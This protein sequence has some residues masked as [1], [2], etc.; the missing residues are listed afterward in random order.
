MEELEYQ[1]CTAC[2]ASLPHTEFHRT[3]RGGRLKKCRV[4][5][6]AARKVWRESHKDKQVQ[7]RRR[8][9]L[10]SY[11]ITEAEYDVMLNAQGGGCA[12]CRKPC[13][14]GRQLAVD[15]DHRSGR[16]RA[17]LC[18]VCNQSLGVYETIREEAARFLAEYGEGNPYISHGVALATERTKRRR[19]SNSRL[20]E[21]I[22]CDIRARYAVGDVT[23]RTLAREYGVSQ[24][25]ISLIVRRGTWPLTEDAGPA[26]GDSSARRD[27]KLVKRVRR[28]TDDQIAEARGLHA[29][30]SSCRTIAAQLGVHHTTIVRLI[31]GEHWKGTVV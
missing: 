21:E 10:A 29:T 28:L 15:H 14:S 22:E 23:Q 31:S 7:Y 1:T 18:V 30:G 3:G 2:R 8:F 11:G 4:C 5:R 19:A 9:N 13:R 25:A 26:S 24:N 16:V 27:D 6:A 17:L 12:I 20:T